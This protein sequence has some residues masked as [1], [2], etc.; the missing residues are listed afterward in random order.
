MLVC[1]EEMGHTGLREL[2]KNV[3]LQMGLGLSDVA[4]RNVT[5]VIATSITIIV[6]II[7]TII[8]VIV[9]MIR[10]NRNAKM[11]AGILQWFM[12]VRVLSTKP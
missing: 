9:T 1:Q 12:G 3:L 6:T 11:K 4:P 10:W 8:I 7:I 5:I 2:P